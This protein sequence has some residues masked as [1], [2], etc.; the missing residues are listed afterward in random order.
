M[1]ERTPVMHSRLSIRSRIQSIPRAMGQLLQF[2][3]PISIRN[4]AV[5]RKSYLQSQHQHMRL[6]FHSLRPI[7]KICQRLQLPI[8]S[9]HISRALLLPVSCASG[10]VPL[11][12]QWMGHMLHEAGGSNTS[13]GIRS[14]RNLPG[15]CWGK[16]W[17]QEPQGVF[18]V[19]EIHRP[20]RMEHGDEK[21]ASQQQEL[22]WHRWS[23]T[24]SRI[25][26]LQLKHT[27][28]R[29]AG[30]GRATI[31]YRDVCFAPSCLSRRL[32]VLSASEHLP[33]IFETTMS[34]SSVVDRVLGS[35]RSFRP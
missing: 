21:Q 27:R 15:R 18:E 24:H 17:I 12:H 3:D 22:V 26:R 1:S 34:C 32:S 30:V 7:F 19:D 23:T 10:R 33:V 5:H 11:L 13:L 14:L 28:P 16:L 4:N 8:R 6:S 29:R 35:R 31:N 9:V 2:S 20:R 25:T